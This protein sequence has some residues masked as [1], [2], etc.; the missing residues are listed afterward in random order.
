MTESSF[1]FSG[2][3]SQDRK[4]DGAGFSGVRTKISR[5]LFRGRR[6]RRSAAPSVLRSLFFSSR[7]IRVESGCSGLGAV[8]GFG[9]RSW[10]FFFGLFFFAPSPRTRSGSMGFWVPGFVSAFAACHSF[11]GLGCLERDVAEK[12]H[13]LHDAASSGESRG[14]FMG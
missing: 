9:R 1:F 2:G 11:H 13:G 5:F 10:C 7:G 4:T 14:F 6:G 12:R 3:R 8:T